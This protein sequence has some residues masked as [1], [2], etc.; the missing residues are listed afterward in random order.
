[1]VGFDVVFDIVVKALLSL[2]MIAGALLFAL[3][4][5]A[6]T[7]IGAPWLQVVCAGAITGFAIVVFVCL[8]LSARGK[9]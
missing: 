3:A 6:G 4:T 1:L 9:L 8:C 2:L 7:I 5:I